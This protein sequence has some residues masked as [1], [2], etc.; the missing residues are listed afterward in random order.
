[1]DKQKGQ[2][3]IIIVLTM[4]MAL[5]V[6]IS[7][8]SRF[9]KSVNVTTKSDSSNRAL[10]ISEALTERL[11]AK[12]Y[13]TLKEYIDYGNC[14]TECALT[15][16]GGDGVLATA[17]AVLSYVGNSTSPLAVS[18]KRD[19]VVEVDLT[20]Y[21]ANKILSVCW[22]NPQ[23]G[24]EASVVGFLVYDTGSN[25]YVLSNFAYN[26]LSSVYSSNCF[27]QADAN[28][29]Y[30]NC[31][32]IAGQTTPK[33]LRLRS[34]Y[35]DVDAFVIPATGVSIPTQGILIKTTGSVQ[36]LTRVISVVKS[37]SSLPTSFD[38]AIQMKSS[39]ETFSN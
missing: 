25:T 6:G 5:A 16:S 37:T 7:A 12:T 32:N 35:N 13:T 38:Y 22:N 36:G 28:Y 4:M 33:L 31:F 15:I 18:L 14:G 21:T 29:G 39:T 30:T 9:I 20:G 10:A 23:S 17:S 24:G 27:S 11:L 3:L 8:S 19:K 34:V 2:T 26:S 1:M